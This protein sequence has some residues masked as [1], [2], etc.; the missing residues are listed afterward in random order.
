MKARAKAVG[1]A[2]LLS[3]GLLFLQG[4]AV[5]RWHNRMM[6]RMMG[7]MMGHDESHLGATPERVIFDRL[8]HAST[9]L[10]HQSE[11]S[12]SAA[13]AKELGSIGLECQKEVIQKE[14]ELRVA[15]VDLG[16]LMERWSRGQADRSDL[17]VKEKEVGSLYAQLLLMPRKTA[18]RARALL[19]EPQQGKLKTL[20]FSPSQGDH[21]GRYR[22]GK[23]RWKQKILAT[24]KEALPFSFCGLGSLLW[25][26]S[27][28]P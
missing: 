16:N 22:E 8:C 20:P 6:E 7:A 4:C 14:A 3:G 12:L 18:E 13:Q 26:S 5:V 2:L 24:S 17:E 11:L 19:T 28:P 25:R 21:R 23:K 9:Y 27:L 10:D 1:V 15:E